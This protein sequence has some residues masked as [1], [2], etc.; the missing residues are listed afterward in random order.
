[1]KVKEFTNNKSYRKNM[2][3]TNLIIKINFFIPHEY[4]SKFSFFMR[5]RLIINREIDHSF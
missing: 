3:R 4:I 2:T 5:K 1:M